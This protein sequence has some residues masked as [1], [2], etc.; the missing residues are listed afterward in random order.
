MKWSGSFD[1]YVPMPVASR[2][3]RWPPASIAPS[4]AQWMAS[5]LSLRRKSSTTSKPCE[6]RS[7][8]N[9]RRQAI[10]FFQGESRDL[11]TLTYQIQLEICRD[12]KTTLQ[13]LPS[14][15]SPKSI[16]SQ[17]KKKKKTTKTVLFMFWWVHRLERQ[18]TIM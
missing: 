9:S 10:D 5:K 8:K 16:S 18:R 15:Y 14:R 4:G 2:S 7:V 12:E 1:P 6:C 11:M 17:Q 3:S 13:S